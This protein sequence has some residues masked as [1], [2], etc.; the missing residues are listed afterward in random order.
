[1]PAQRR[2]AFLA[3][4]AL[5][6]AAVCLSACGVKGDL[7]PP[8]AAGPAATEAVPEHP[9]APSEST[10]KVFLEQSV[11]QSKGPEAVLP[12][13][14]PKEWEK[15]GDYQ[16]ARAKGAVPRNTLSEPDPAKPFVLDWLL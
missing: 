10:R 8:P 16:P 7:D 15:N 4:F 2:S 1:M 11:V 14:P 5:L 9:V 13:M 12:R 3:A 6:S